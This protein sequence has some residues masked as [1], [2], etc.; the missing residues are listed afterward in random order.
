MLNQG[1]PKLH[2]LFRF[3]LLGG[4]WSLDRETTA[5][6]RAVGSRRRHP[7]S[8]ESRGEPMRCRRAWRGVAKGSGVGPNI[9]MPK[10]S[11]RSAQCTDDPDVFRLLVEDNISSYTILEFPRRVCVC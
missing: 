2:P 3:F 9:H 1:C 7:E 10:K 8:D 4:L 6:V 11:G 5:S